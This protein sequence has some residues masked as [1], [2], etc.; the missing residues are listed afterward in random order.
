[1]SIQQKILTYFSATAIGL[2]G[3][4]LFFIY[5]LFYEFREEE[6]QQRQK[7]RI[8]VT[9]DYLSRVKQM[10]SDIVSSLDKVTIERIYDEK[11]LIFNGNKE[12]IY[13]S[14]D[15]TEIPYYGK[16]L[17]RLSPGLNWIEQKDGR[18][19]VVGICFESDSKS[20]YGISKAYDA[21]GYTKLEF[22]RT[23]LIINFILISLIIISVSFYLARRISKPLK[24]VAETIAA[25]NF[26]RDD[27]PLMTKETN[28]EIAVLTAR[29][30]EL[31]QRMRE[32]F[33]F[34]KHAI[35][36][37]SHELKTPV[38]ILVSNFERM[39]KEEDPEKLRA[40]IKDQKEDTKALSEIIDALLEIS[41]TETG[42]EMKK[43]PIRPDE[44]IFDIAEEL[45][46]LRPGFKFNVAYAEAIEAAEDLT[47]SGNERLLKSALTNLMFNC[48][49]YSDTEEAEVHISGRKGGVSVE[50]V[51]EGR[52][53]GAKEQEFMFRHF[54]RGEN[55]RGKRGFGLGLVF[56][57]K[58]MEMHGGEITYRS[59]A[60]RRNVFTVHLPR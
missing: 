23:V 57:H 17:E 47:V 27:S 4:S 44:M 53:I 2:T 20:Y 29:F 39:E 54:F 25:Y 7:K 16:I 31:M 41:K 8:T 24:E 60:G 38:S 12:L 18:Y 9:L 32:A 45:Q 48:I 55:S 3:I 21:Y 30:N 59:E 43:T 37:I 42:S 34:R 22:L 11:L 56:I 35:H 40:Q 19:D 1:M 5:T 46:R 33:S 49:Q 50:F 15:D 36:H 51:N 58:I 28:N 6:F 52:V 10:D 13:E 26:E 14:I